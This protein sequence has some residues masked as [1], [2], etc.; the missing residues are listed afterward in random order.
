M[1][2]GEVNSKVNDICRTFVI[3]YVKDE[4]KLVLLRANK[5]R[6]TPVSDILCKCHSEKRKG[7]GG[8]EAG[9]K[10]LTENCLGNDMVAWRKKRGSNSVMS[11]GFVV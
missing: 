9:V 4:I 11:L 10:R 1:R 3:C 8:R 2:R 7:E 5:T 6:V